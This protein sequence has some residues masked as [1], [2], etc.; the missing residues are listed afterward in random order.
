MAL[1][2]APRTGVPQWSD[3][4]D[5]VMRADF[6]TGFA[7][8]EDRAVV[9]LAPAAGAPPAA[10]VVNRLYLNL[11]TGVVYFDDGAAWH[12][13]GSVVGVVGEIAASAP[14]D[15]AAAG[16][17]GHVADA[18]HK[19]A[20]E[21]WGVDANLSTS[22]PGDLAAAGA[23]GRVADAAHRHVREAWGLAG[24]IDMS[25]PGDAGAAG[26]SGRVADAAH[27]HGREAAPTATG[28]GAVHVAGDT[29][30]GVL[31][32]T[33]GW[34]DADLALLAWTS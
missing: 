18:G 5:G 16:A 22:H 19:H 4:D 25:L 28:L 11:T 31:N 21:Q 2:F 33:S 14:G 26:G 24:D 10:G 13:I 20:R 12:P 3:P 32:F 34:S 1:T 8:L 17:T 15:A 29:M 9:A 23:A 27:Q 30:T 7:N 6:D